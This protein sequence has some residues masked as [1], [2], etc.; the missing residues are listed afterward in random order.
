ME[1]LESRLEGV[2]LLR[3]AEG[4]KGPDEVRTEAREL[5]SSPTRAIVQEME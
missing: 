1:S 4:G 5:L 2:R 3:L